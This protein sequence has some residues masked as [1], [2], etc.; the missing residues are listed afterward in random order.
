MSLD[1]LLEPIPAKHQPCKLARIIAGLEE[2]YQSALKKLVE[3]SWRDGGLSD[4][5]LRQRMLKAGIEV[6]ATVI[7]YHRRGICACAKGLVG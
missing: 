2:P 7:H 5:D 4:S 3:T 6:G 1:I